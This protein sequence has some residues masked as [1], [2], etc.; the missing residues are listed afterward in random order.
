MFVQV[1]AGKE[2]SGYTAYVM[3][4]FYYNALSNHSTEAVN[5]VI[6]FI[7]SY[8]DIP[9]DGVMLDE[10]ENEHIKPP[11]EMMFKLTDFRLRSFSLPFAKELEK[12]T[13]ESASQTLFNMQFAPDGKPEIRMKAINAYMDL[14]REGAMHVEDAMYKRAKELY[15]PNCFIAAH[16]TFHNSLIND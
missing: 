13:G 3:V 14:M 10:Y 11:W 1:Q 12:R 6:N 8:S 5:G 15:G 2:Y 4:E 16:N 7:N 9:L